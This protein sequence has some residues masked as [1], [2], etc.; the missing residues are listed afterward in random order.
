MIFG[1]TNGPRVEFMSISLGTSLG[2][3][4]PDQGSPT[5][6]E[7]VN[8]CNKTAS[9]VTVA[10]CKTTNGIDFYYLHT[11]EVDPH[12]SFLFT[13]HAIVLSNGQVLRALASATNA[14]DL[15]V[16]GIQSIR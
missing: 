6:I 7:S 9:A 10:L 12:S 5:H 16:V 1:S 11:L 15:S 14:I 8:F 4:V 3:V 13:D 2:V